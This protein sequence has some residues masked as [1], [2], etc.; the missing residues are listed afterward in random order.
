MGEGPASSFFLFRRLPVILE[1]SD[2]ARF[3]IAC[4]SSDESFFLS[5]CEQHHSN[6]PSLLEGRSFRAPA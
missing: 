2:E 5:Q 4:F 1:R 6:A 3:S